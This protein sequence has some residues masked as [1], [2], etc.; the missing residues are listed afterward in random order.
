MTLNELKNELPPID[1]NITYNEF[2]RG[3]EAFYNNIKEEGKDINLYLEGLKQMASI[4]L[5]PDPL[6]DLG[7]IQEGSSLVL[8]TAGYCELMPDVNITAHCVYKNDDFTY[9]L[10]NAYIEHKP[11]LD[12][13]GDFIGAYCLVEKAN[14][15]K[16]LDYL[17]KASIDYCKSFSTSLGKDAPWNRWY[18]EMARKTAVKRA[19]KYVCKG[20]KLD[21][22]KTA[23]AIDN[24]DNDLIRGNEGS[25]SKINIWE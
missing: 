14:G 19:M 15:G 12:N 20:T 25:L 18:E 3:L 17:N 8:K 11:N 5:N 1:S 2:Y 21:L 24:L 23:E 13:R 22:Y 7:Y 6:L 10:S 16:H 9:T 4:G